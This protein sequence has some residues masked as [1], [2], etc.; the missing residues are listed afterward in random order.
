MTDEVPNYPNKVRLKKTPVVLK[1]DEEGF[2]KGIDY[3]YSLI[4]PEND[5]KPLALAKA[6]SMNKNIKIHRHGGMRGVA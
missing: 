2:C 4:S 5:M 1:F 3:G 6:R